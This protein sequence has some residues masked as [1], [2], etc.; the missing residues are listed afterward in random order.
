MIRRTAFQSVFVALLLG[1]AAALLLAVLPRLPE[2]VV[3]RAGDV[4]P[5]LADG[6]TAQLRNFFGFY[7]VEAEGATRFRW[8]SGE[9]SFV[10]RSGARLGAPLL[11]TLRVCGCR[12]GS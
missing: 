7:A 1:A 8:T 10:V 6:E 11:L 2:R 4:G 5:L 12:A 9:G 3:V